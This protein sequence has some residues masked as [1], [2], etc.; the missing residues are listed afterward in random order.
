MNAGCVA[1]LLASSTTSHSRLLVCFM[2]TALTQRHTCP[3]NGGPQWEA[4]ATA[5]GVPHDLLMWMLPHCHGMGG[6][7]KLTGGAGSST[8]LREACLGL[9]RVTL[10]Y[11]SG[12]TGAPLP[13]STFAAA[14]RQ[15]R[16]WRCHTAQLWQ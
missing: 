15:P 16:S 6:T 7:G 10:L 13:S 8:H 11:K 14:T 5:A 12:V 4:L 2:H 3:Q 1:L 9:Q